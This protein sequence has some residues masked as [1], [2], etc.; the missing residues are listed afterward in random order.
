MG[1]DRDL[2]P[3]AARR[4]GAGPGH[5][6]GHA[7]PVRSA[8][9]SGGDGTVSE[10]PRGDPAGVA[11][12]RH[13]GVRA[14]L[15]RISSPPSS[16]V[17]PPTTRPPRSAYG[18]LDRGLATLFGDRPTWTSTATHAV[19]PLLASDSGV[20]LQL[21]TGIASHRRRFGDWIGG[22]WLPECA[23]APWLDPLLEEAG[24]RATC[25]ELTG[26]FG[27]GGTRASAPARDRRRA[28]SCGRSTDRRSRSYGALTGYPAG[29]AYRDYHELTRHHH[30]VLEQRR[31]PLRPRSG[32][33]ARAR[34][35]ARLR[36]PGART[37]RERGR[38]RV[39]ARHRAARPLVVRGRAVARGGD[40]G[41]G[42][43]GA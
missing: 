6:V 34:A 24:V 29:G 12:T 23:Y 18:A 9:G 32:P 26:L 28:Q 37:G 27:L 11:P 36:R 16:S 43:A 20:G 8:R 41:V 13:R 33:R 35:R 7:G 15:G 2:L 25:V 21:Q 30:R 4:A 1:G 42:P 31:A 38:L 3:A 10:V 14:R 17:R 22:F 39:R 40:R 19:L 5:A